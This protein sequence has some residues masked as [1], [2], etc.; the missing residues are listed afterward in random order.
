MR[1]A[2]PIRLAVCLAALAALAA[3]A[4]GAGGDETTAETEGERLFTQWLGLYVSGEKVGYETL[5]VYRLPPA[6]PGAPGPGYRFTVNTF[7][8]TRPDAADA[9]FVKTIEA[10]VD[11]DG[12]PRSL[13]CRVALERR[14][15][16]VTGERRGPRFALRRTVGSETA[17]AEVPLE[18]G[19][20]FR[21]WTVLATFLGKTEAGDT[22][23][24]TALDES[25]GAVLAQPCLVR[26]LGPRSVPTG[27]RE[28]LQGTAVVEGVGTDVIAHLLDA[29][30]RTLRSVW[31]SAPIVAAGTSLSDARRLDAPPDGPRGLDIPGL[32][33]GRYRNARLGYSLYVPPY[34]F[35]A[36]V[37]D[38]A[39]A[40]CV[41]D[42]T[43]GT[44]VTVQPAVDPRLATRGA[45]DEALLAMADLAQGQWAARFDACDAQ[46]PCE[47]QLAGRPARLVTGSA[48]LGCTTF[49]F[50]CYFVAGEGF[51]YL[52]TAL[53][54]DRPLEAEPA[55]ADAV[56]RSLR[57]EPPAAQLPIRTIGNRVAI[58]YYGIEV[59]RPSEAWKIPRHLG[60][61]EALLEL[62]REDRAAAAVLRILAPTAGQS[63]AEF[64]ADRAAR[65]AET[66]AVARPEPTAVTVAGRDAV[67]F[68]YEADLLAGRPAEGV[69]LYVPL[70]SVVL[71]L[72]L[73]GAKGDA[74]ARADLDR[75]RASL[76]LAPASKAPDPAPAKKGD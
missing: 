6:D 7:L 73:I 38:E 5:S 2:G 63:L 35:I 20:T 45:S 1:P 53:R 57:F 13:D 59:E 3:P 19:L 41:S 8:K 31:Q 47:T 66:Y 17:E 23:Q 34:P 32:E 64:A 74:G 14:T 67:E 62:V 16:H 48:R 27:L 37:L 75:L 15:W 46:P 68:H 39:G 18:P 54:P 43:D 69:A 24:W 72:V 21:A 28:S 61:P 10:S 40:A 58:P 65:A 52:V 22:V 11:S 29:E 26:L 30:G 33:A 12:L 9:R 49:R 60:G 36:T 55:L 70:D 50:A 76:R 4:R 51:A 42:A 44:S 25:L 71:E 56:L